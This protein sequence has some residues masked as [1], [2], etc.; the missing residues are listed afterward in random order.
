MKK[1]QGQMAAA[2]PLTALIAWA[3]NGSF[4]DMQMSV[5][6]AGAMGGI[7]GPIVAWA[8]S[9]IPKPGE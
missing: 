5:E 6:V 3:W 4:P 1:V 8:V 2:A 7:V 9:W